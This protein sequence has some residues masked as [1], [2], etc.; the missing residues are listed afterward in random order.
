MTPFEGIKVLDTSHVLAGPF[1]S[2]Q[3]G[4]L[5]AEVI[6]VDNPDGR[7]M[8]RYG[9]NDP[10]LGGRGLGPGF[11]MQ[12]AGKRSISLN[13]KEP[14]A[15]DIFR[16]LADQSDV[17]V[18]N[19]RPGVLS[20]LGIGQQDL[21]SSNE[22][23]IWCAITGFGQDGPMSENPAYDH[24]V[25]AFTGMMVAN[26]DDSGR[27]RRIGFP[28]I[29]YIVGLLA[30]FAVSS[31]LFERSRSGSIKIRLRRSRIGGCLSSEKSLPEWS[32]SYHRIRRLDHHMQ[33]DIAVNDV[34][35]ALTYHEVTGRT[36]DDDFTTGPA[37]LGLACHRVRVQ[38][39]PL[40]E[41]HEVAQPLD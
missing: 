15:V 33:R 13:L 8:V 30:A 18:E 22:R 6:R 29:D 16:K 28:L 40:R 23:L 36:A 37:E 1:C 35:T 11:V 21:C 17:V 20:R 39:S 12:N 38:V 10:K 7:D 19:F 26:G 41:R 2:Y 3:L 34:I 31:A 4:L 14:R 25:Q 32:G 24:I 27:P 9:G 5:G